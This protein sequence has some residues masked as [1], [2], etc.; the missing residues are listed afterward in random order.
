MAAKETFEKLFPIYLDQINKAGLLATH[1]AQTSGA[2]ARLSSQNHMRRQPSQGVPSEWAQGELLRKA[3]GQGTLERSKLLNSV[4]IWCQTFLYPS[5]FL[6]FCL[7]RFVFQTCRQNQWPLS[8]FRLSLGWDR[9]QNGMGQLRASGGTDSGFPLSNV[10][11][12]KK[13]DEIF[14]D[15]FLTPEYG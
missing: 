3:A 14:K 4:D 13:L 6:R 8:S 7:T 12:T 10:R 15:V 2:A 9:R 1:G 5:G 11:V